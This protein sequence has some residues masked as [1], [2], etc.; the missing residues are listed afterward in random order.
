[1]QDKTSLIFIALPAVYGSFISHI[2]T[3]PDRERE[4]IVYAA[5]LLRESLESIL[6]KEIEEADYDVLDVD[7]DG[8][9]GGI[10][11]SAALVHMSRLIYQLMSEYEK[12]LHNPFMVEFYQSVLRHVIS[13]YVLLLKNRSIELSEVGDPRRVEEKYANG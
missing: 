11:F 10:T 2:W 4:R 1:M 13:F 5:S 12:A 6:G 3:T 9:N 7:Q 8:K